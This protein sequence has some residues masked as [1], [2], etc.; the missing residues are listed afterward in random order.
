MKLRRRPLSQRS[1]AN[2][3]F[4]PAMRY[5]AIVL[6]NALIWQPV[7]VLAEG[8]K[9]APGS[10]NTRMDRAG[11]GVPVVNIATPNGKGV[12][13]NTF[14]DY[15]VDRQGLILNNGRDKFTDTQLG[16]KIL[17]NPNLRDRA[18]QLIINEVNGG[19]P[20]RL[21][22]YTEVAGQ[23]A[24][25]VVA[26]PF[27]ITCNGCGFINMPRATLSTGKPVF[28]DGE[29]DHFAVDQGQV[30]IE[31]L[32]LDATEVDRF[33]IITRAARLNAEVHANEL[34]VVTGA[35]DV[36]ADSL[37]TTRRKGTG[38]KPELA[39]D[40]SALGGMY[41]GSIRLVGTEAG[42]G[43]KM[44]GDMA[45]SGGDIRID[46]NGQ[47]T[48]TN[49]SST[50]RMVAKARN[51]SLEGNV[52]AREAVDVQ[53][54]DDLKVAGALT[55]AGNIDLRAGQRLSN[56]G[57]VVAG[58]EN[59]TRRAA[60]DLNIQAGQLDNQGRLDA[61]QHL[62]INVSQATNSGQIVAQTVKVGAD[63]HLTNR[64]TLVGDNVSLNSEIIT[65][66]GQQATLAG[67]SSL[68]LDSQELNNL[69]GTVQFARGQDVSLDL[70]RFDNSGGSLVLDDAN[71]SGQVSQLH[72]R[73][74]TLG[75]N[76]I[77][78]QADSVDN[79][80]GGRMEAKALTLNTTEA[81]NN[82]RGALQAVNRLTL[83]AGSLDNTQGTVSGNDVNLTTAQTLTNQRGLI[84]AND[85]RLDVDA[86]SA[87]NNRAGTV[88]SAQGD[89]AITAASL[90]NRDGQVLA[91]Q[92]ITADVS[93]RID[94]R[95][96]S[97]EGGF[98]NARNVHLS[99]GELDNTESIV[100]ASRDLRLD[101]SGK[102]VNTRGHAQA[103]QALTLSAA[104]LNNRQGTLAGDTV[105]VTTRK[106]LN[107]Q[108]GLISAEDGLLT[109][110]T[111]GALNNPAGTVQSRQ[112]D[113]HL[114]ATQVD[115]RD[116]QLVA[117]GAATVTASGEIDNSTQ[118]QDAS[119]APARDDVIPGGAINGQQVT[120]NAAQLTN[121]GGLVDGE[122]VELTLDRL[123]N[124]Q[125][126][127]SAKH[128]LALNMAE[129]LHNDGGRLQVIEGDLT[130]TG[131]SSQSTSQKA[132]LDN[133]QGVMV[134]RYL[135][136]YQL[137]SV[138]N[139][140]GQ[141]VGDRVHLQAAS[142]SNQK[143]TIAAGGEQLEDTLTVT[144]GGKL[145]NTNGTLQALQGT[146]LAAGSLENA[147]GDISGRDVR[148]T[149]SAD[150]HNS[151]GGVISAE[152]HLTADVGE[153]LDN[154]SGFLQALQGNTT[155][156][157]G[158]L[159]NS[160]GKVLAQQALDV[161]SDAELINAAGTLLAMTGDMELTAGRLDNREG[162]LVAGQVDDDGQLSATQNLTVQLGNGTLDN[163][164]GGQV[165]GND[166]TLRLARLNNGD[167]DTSAGQ[168][169]VVGADSALNLYLS[170]WLHNRQ[171]RLQ[172]VDGA[173]T[174]HGAGAQLDNAQGTIEAQR[175]TLGDTDKALGEVSN[176][177]GVMAADRITL[178]VANLDNTQQGLIAAGAGGLTLH[179]SDTLNNQGGKLQSDAQASLM[180]ER[181]NNQQGGVILAD[182][183]TLKAVRLLNQQGVILGEGQQTTLNLSG[184]STSD[185]ALDNQGGT[186]DI[187]DGNLIV[188]A[189]SGRV[190]NRGGWLGAD[191][192]T[193]DAQ[194]LNNQDGQVVTT[195]GDMQL[196]VDELNN[197]GGTLLAQGGFLGADFTTLR[198]QGG[199]LQGDS[200]E[201]SGRA[202]E[203]DDN[204]QITALKGDATLTLK[205]RLSNLGGK[206]LALG[207]LFVG[208]SKDEAPT[209]DINNSEGGQLAGN[210][211]ILRA[212]TLTNSDGGI[213][214]A[215]K[216]LDISADSLTNTAGYINSLGGD[217]SR[218]I[219]DNTLNNAGGA[220]ELASR[221]ARLEANVLDN[222][223]GSV[224]HAGDG[225]LALMT[226]RLN[227]SGGEV[228][229]TGSAAIT[230]DK[231]AES[232]SLG[233]WQF[234]DA[235]T[236]A[237][238]QAL[239]LKQ[240][241]RIATAGALTLNAPGLENAGALL[242]NG[243]LTLGIRGDGITNSGQIS[244][245]G[246]LDITAP[247]LTNTG[248][249]AS[250][251]T[252]AY[253]LAGKLD[254][255]GRLV[256]GGH[257]DIDAANLDNNG[258]LGSQNN[259]TI[260]LTS[261]GNINQYAD[262]LMFAGGDM[263]L[264]ADRL[265][266]QYGDI[267][268]MGDLTFAKDAKGDRAA[269]L[270]NRSG[271]IEAEGN[272]TLL[273]ENILNTR[274]VLTV[275][276]QSG[277]G[278]TIEAEK[279]LVRGYDIKHG[280]QNCDG[281][282]GVSPCKVPN[283]E[284]D[285]YHYTVTVA[286]QRESKITD[287]SDQGVIATGGDLLMEGEDITNDSSSMLAN[288]NVTIIADK[289]FTN[290][291][292]LNTQTEQVSIYEFDLSKYS[293]EWEN[294]ASN[295]WEP[296]VVPNERIAEF[297]REVADWIAQGGVN[298]EGEALPL[299]KRLNDANKTQGTP[300][301]V[302]VLDG[303]AHAIVQAGNKV[304]INAGSRIQNGEINE[305]T[306]S[307][308]NGQLGDISTVGPVDNVSLTLNRRTD[309]AEAIQ[310]NNATGA[311]RSNVDKGGRLTASGLDNT[312]AQ[313][314]TAK[315]ADPAAPAGNSM[316]A[317]GDIEAPDYSDVA[318]ERVSPTEQG[319]FRLP[320][321]D[322][323][324]FIHNTSPNSRYLI[325]TNPEFTTLDGIL[326][327]DYLLDKLGYSDDNAYRLLGDGR[328]ESRL[329]RDSVLNT[330]GSRYLE[331]GL[332]DDYAQYR[333]LMDNAIAAQDALNLRV[334]V[335]L[336]PAQTAAL[337]HDIVWMEE[338]VIN[339]QK[340]LAPVLYLAQLDDR[341]VRGG[342]II[343][344]RD[345][346]LISGGDLVNV[347]TIRASNDMSIDSGGSILQGGLID[348]GNNLDLHAR[349][350][351]RNA[352]A[353][354]IR[355]GDVRLRTDLGDIINDRLA[356][357][358]GVEDNYRTYLDQGGLISARDSLT[359]GA[360]RDV[361]NRSD[362]VSGGDARVSAG[363][364]VRFEAV[365]DVSHEQVGDGINAI[366]RDTVTPIS[367][368]LVSG[369]D[370]SVA[371]GRD[372]Q[373]TAS[374]LQSD[375]QL[376]M[377]AGRDITLDAAQNSAAVDARR[378]YSER[379]E[380]V[381]TT[382]SANDDVTLQAGN[383]VT[384]VAAK[385]DAGGNLAVAA[386]NDITL[387]S[388]ADSTD[389]ASAT[390]RK[391][392]VDSHTR[393]QGTELT[394]GGNASLEA[395]HDVTMVASKVA[396]NDSAYV[397]AGNDVTLA[398]A[399][400]EDYSLY[401]K[402]SSGGG[403]FGSQKTKRDEVSETRA[404]GSEIRAGDGNLIIASGNDQTYQGARL[405]AGNDLVLN[406]GGEI[407]FATASDVR[408]ESHTKDKSSFA[409][410]S[411]KGKG[412]TD[413]T[414]RQSQLVAQGERI[415]QAAQG[416][417]VDLPENGEVTQ[418]SVSRTID[419]MVQADP[420]LAW[421]QD[422]EQRGDIDWRQVK[423]THDSWSYDHSGM[424]GAAQ[425]VVA[426][427]VTYFTAGAASG[428]IVGATGSAAAGAAGGAVAGAV[429][430]NAAVSTIN[431]E[432][433]LGNALDDTFSSDAVRGYAVAGI[434]AGLTAGFYDGL[435]GTETGTSTAL[436]NSGNVATNAGLDTWQG[437][438]QF[439][440]NQ[441]LQNSTSALL[442]QALG[443][444]ADLGVA[445]Q[446]SLANAF[447][448][449][450]FN[451]IGDFTQGNANFS[452]GSLSKAAL[453]GVMGGLAAEATGGDFKTGA[454]AAGINELLVDKLANEYAGM[455]PD[456][457]AGLL[458]MN[459][460][461]IGVLAGAA[462]G[463]VNDA[464][465]LQTGAQ[466]AANATQYNYLRHD[467][468]D[469]YAKELEGCAERGDC[470]DVRDKYIDISE[471]QQQE[472]VS[473]C[474]V[475]AVACQTKRSQLL[476]D[477]DKFYSS[478]ERLDQVAVG[479]ASETLS[480]LECSI[481][482]RLQ[483]GQKKRLSKT[484]WSMLVWIEKRQAI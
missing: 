8:I 102:L 317:T 62:G 54:R 308:I 302:T 103:G 245:Q 375:G 357:N 154:A 129:W 428:A 197:R 44:A 237:L 270:E 64:G 396:A 358:A 33:D 435:T 288:G 268:A 51:A 84:S 79:S 292:A 3:R 445:L 188:N 7:I 432:G 305:N 88:Q 68:A 123:D 80:A 98:I 162:M 82:T 227:N 397:Y 4:R 462:T 447:A 207:E 236:L 277:D 74:G 437:V 386:G 137:G 169:G 93:G 65:N 19:S 209:P 368:Q 17:G 179:L 48:V 94:N 408:T 113:L 174:V 157:A 477:E 148:L 304:T 104:S 390:A 271:T 294:Q 114:T 466:V 55:S 218:I 481:L 29:L 166:V 282:G 280:T 235:L 105:N 457:K 471:K 182:N 452:E 59:D 290:N 297:D 150:V 9:V 243:D 86:G 338:Q 26:N 139:R 309:T 228:T 356:V 201:L 231:L 152:R 203:N 89:V 399:N 259:L 111:G 482:T 451:A 429:A 180:A 234:N 483:Q 106:D 345:V 472:L 303:G 395:G 337:T 301:V 298:E 272:M 87:L 400:D 116:G 476:A 379:V 36:D 336:T 300:P 172:V 423:E 43:V 187:K 164:R 211:V 361:I 178:N 126:T 183:I 434:T 448:A 2:T 35:N 185:P 39:V 81:V 392:R 254:N 425:L 438:G 107:N 247:R 391:K 417:T 199:T 265:F 181:I 295:G 325:E 382:L 387:V 1:S 328:Y 446:N 412:S 419:A 384:A 170:E 149:V 76:V 141:I 142:L 276:E 381:G 409:W 70:A 22:G 193:I 6:I 63:Q 163:R 77:D 474:A 269:S 394:A 160:N 213:I 127:I 346:E 470:K 220:I 18:A 326:G 119:S 403:F 16:G 134:A 78:L 279:T 347:G 312:T 453:H 205:Q 468:V 421:L 147:G 224:K 225:V 138:N 34:N 293:I 161:T 363:R 344:G 108:G 57:Q 316:Q 343:Q 281:Y 221:N 463:G 332:E 91:Q 398:A 473:Y 440:A 210:T 251:E 252:S 322:Y 341:N 420:E 456:K 196:T 75:A 171:G 49:A 194:H 214:E 5:C 223:Q 85:G 306:L 14:S 133:T 296:V 410:Q 257:L 71:L 315:G 469:A 52:H 232:S 165:I 351:I 144:L 92:V 20:S 215:S 311:E 125:G 464:D 230:L 263:A 45:A 291:S 319:S 100:S 42:V 40:S 431:N 349:D 411:N 374:D 262:S 115:N 73:G 415:I 101:V 246:Q 10:G 146:T 454:L 28:K 226:D 198:N 370:T 362:L 275:E 313:V 287:N 242:A 455:S 376:A 299:P 393:Q 58:I 353:G 484:S 135:N 189:G 465:N 90:D 66:Q 264:Y 11:N 136:L 339:G 475:G 206:I 69:G 200:I 112:G 459:S 145:D 25:V 329:I 359:I 422:M 365:A 369:G 256:S 284:R 427:V 99:A 261:G 31:G 110:N 318:F 441:V 260:D 190:D 430:S 23:R 323:G 461:L 380:Q 478:L 156:T 96:D 414:L 450:G 233:N 426:I 385:V 53:A 238:Q 405:E 219:V 83:T 424:S 436:S 208:A 479:E 176:A 117:L 216:K 406:S 307:Q 21:R 267:Y 342:S 30:A 480:L 377:A 50:G 97:G 373:F 444:D 212:G 192:L 121:T 273:A 331:A 330:T 12:S 204:G 348:A 153:Q 286:E 32:G 378:H 327:S 439:T 184:A 352:L 195:Q 24:N 37:A 360:G 314:D 143:G 285:S 443:G 168:G 124:A 350:D 118:Q 283:E 367:S 38:E 158:S 159:D 109:L 175:L 389:E 334:G 460:Q 177:G 120:V 241:E 56:A 244:S 333:Y 258:T 202:L 67:T 128:D 253:H 130:L 249:I 151:A 402:H 372:I 186:I 222:Q 404:V 355:G 173:L 388:A 467:Q 47:L 371:A 140:Q 229:G 155:L 131:T 46:A 458:V 72:N 95:V 433:N 167:Q 401:K 240:G 442:D 383:N 278:Q 61:T 274:D 255:Q 266:N 416:I 41:A 248:R 354:E 324:L 13:H 321:G 449:A 217:N 250:A 132:A 15:N 413:E 340:V 335:G 191:A 239:V 289:T 418:Q 407:H 60:G 122:G 27:G 366:Y 320:K 310:A 364:D